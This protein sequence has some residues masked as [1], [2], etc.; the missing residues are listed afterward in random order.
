MRRER[1][2]K[3]SGKT[4]LFKEGIKTLNLNRTMG[5]WSKIAK[6]FTVSL[7]PVKEGWGVVVG[8]GWIWLD[9]VGLA[10]TEVEAFLDIAKKSGEFDIAVSG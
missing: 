9:W 10:W 1:F 6:N 5:M 2:R 7:P 4:Q 3:C 8:F